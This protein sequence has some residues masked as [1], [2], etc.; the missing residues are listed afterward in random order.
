MCAGGVITTTLFRV[1]SLGERNT[2][3]ICWADVVCEK[4]DKRQKVAGAIH[5]KI[6]VWVFIVLRS[7][8]K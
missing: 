1:V 5:L 7:F 6:V 3:L 8:E 2:V 4:A